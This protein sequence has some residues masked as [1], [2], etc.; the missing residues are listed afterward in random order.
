MCYQLILAAALPRVLG[1][2][3]ATVMYIDTEKKFS[4]QRLL[5]MA[6]A[7][8]Q[9]SHLSLAGLDEVLTRVLV[10]SPDS[11]EALQQSLV[12]LEKQIAARDI[13]LVVLDSVAA[14][15]RLDFGEAKQTLQRQEHLGQQAVTLKRLAEEH[16]IPVVVT[17]Q[18][19]S[20]PNAAAAHTFQQAGGAGA[21]GGSSSN[22]GFLTAALG[23]KWA[24]CVNVRLVLERFGTR[25]FV[26]I[27]KSPLS[28][29]RVF[30][31]AITSSGLQQV[32]GSQLPEE[33]LESAVAINIA[34][35]FAP[36]AGDIA[37]GY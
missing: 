28:A 1:G 11:I 23:P 14:L 32:E 37:G 33:L 19:T 18:V 29:N 26:R 3:E 16:R 5:E 20:R 17:N 31:Y 22:S 30:E 34:N 15:L 36:D 4:S 10:M 9:G 7:R 27:A 2:G 24:H 6:Q 35:E 8:F 21:R 12:L 13:Q 25:R